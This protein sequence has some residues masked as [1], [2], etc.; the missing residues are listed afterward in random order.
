MLA[1][2]ELHELFALKHLQ[3]HRARAHGDEQKQKQ[4]FRGRDAPLITL[5]GS[6]HGSTIICPFSGGIMPR[7]RLASACKFS[8]EVILARSILSS[9][10]SCSNRFC[11]LLAVESTKPICTTCRRS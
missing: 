10:F 6:S 3:L 7:R 11:N 2:A 1:L 8:G 9:R 4:Y 5:Q